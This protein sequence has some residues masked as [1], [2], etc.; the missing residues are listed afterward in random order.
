MSTVSEA[1]KATQISTFVVNHYATSSAV[2]VPSINAAPH[3]KNVVV[4]G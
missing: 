4:S 1:F 3:R 2:H